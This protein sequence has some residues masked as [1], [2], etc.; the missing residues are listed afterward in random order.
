M[1]VSQCAEEL[2]ESNKLQLVGKFENLY[3]GR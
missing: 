1:I 3:V 2:R